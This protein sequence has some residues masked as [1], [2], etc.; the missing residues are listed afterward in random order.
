METEEAAATSTEK[1]QEE[2]SLQHDVLG[3]LHMCWA[4]S[5]HACC[6]PIFTPFSHGRCYL[7]LTEVNITAW[8]SAYWE[9]IELVSHASKP[10]IAK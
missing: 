6:L 4:F 1:S 9:I 3:Q 8:I 5:K 7:H 10:E 2:K